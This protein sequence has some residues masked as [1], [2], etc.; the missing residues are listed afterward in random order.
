M[1]LRVCVN[2]ISLRPDTLVTLNVDGV[3]ACTGA[4]RGAMSHDE[5]KWKH[6]AGPLRFASQTG[7]RANRCPPSLGIVHLRVPWYSFPGWD[8][9]GTRVCHLAETSHPKASEH[10]AKIL[11]SGLQR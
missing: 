7:P 4:G 10:S 5:D 8:G 9:R 2:G 3:Y 1:G 6:G 11:K